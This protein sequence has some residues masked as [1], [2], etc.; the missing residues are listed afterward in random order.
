MECEFSDFKAALDSSDPLIVHRFR[1]VALQLQSLCKMKTEKSVLDELSHLPKQLGDIYS[2]LFEQM[3][4]DTFSFQIAMKALK[5]LACSQRPLPTSDFLI[6]TSQPNLISSSE[7]LD[8]CC[9]LIIEDKNLGIFRFAHLTVREF[10]ES[11]DGFRQVDL[12]ILAAEICLQRVAKMRPIRRQSNDQQPQNDLL[13]YSILFWPVH[14]QLS[15]ELRAQ[16]PLAPLLSTLLVQRRASN[17][18]SKWME[19]ART[20]VEELNEESEIREKLRYSFCSPAHPFFL[21]CVFGFTEVVEKSDIPVAQKCELGLTGLHLASKYGNSEVV[22]IL[23]ARGASNRFRDTYGRTSLFH[24][25]QKGHLKVV[26][27]FMVHEKDIE[28]SNEILKQAMILSQNETHITEMVKLLTSRNSDLLTNRYVLQAA[29]MAPTRDLADYIRNEVGYFESSQTLLEIAACANNTELLEFLLEGEDGDKLI[30]DVDV[31]DC[32]FS[33]YQP[34]KKAFEPLF[35]AVEMSAIPNNELLRLFSR[36]GL[37]P[38]KFLLDSGRITT[39]SQDAFKSAAKHPWDGLEML[40]LLRSH[41]PDLNVDTNIVITAADNRDSVQALAIMEYLLYLN[42][43]VSV[44]QIVVERA[45][46]HG[47]QALTQYLLENFDYLQITDEL[48]EKATTSHRGTTMLKFLLETR[49]N[50]KINQSLLHNAA[51]FADQKVLES[52]LAR[53]PDV[54]VDEQVFLSAVTTNK[55]SAVRFLL[56]HASGLRIS[57]DIIK[58]AINHSDFY[59]STDYDIN[60]ELD[61]PKHPLRFDES[62]NATDI[63]HLILTRVAE[64]R[65]TESISLVAA[66]S[67]NARACLGYLIARYG[68]V[69]VT[70][71]VWIA[72]ASNGYNGGVEV[73]LGQELRPTDMEAILLQVAGMGPSETLD[74]LLQDAGDRVDHKKWNGIASLTKAALSD[75]AGKVRDL[76]ASGIPPIAEFTLPGFRSRSNYLHLASERSEETLKAILETGALDID[77]RDSWGY[78]ALMRAARSGNEATVRLLLQ[79][80][81]DLESQL[82]NGKTALSLVEDA[83][84]AVV[85]LLRNWKLKNEISGTKGVLVSH[86]TMTVKEV[87]SS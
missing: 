83:N 30:I 55:P 67:D 32:L 45:V 38:L 49:P 46:Y 70:D 20:A 17:S 62:H 5:L 81:A 78:T 68:S 47:H 3:R 22:K 13:N 11:R 25:V 10:L 12:H 82:K 66:A 14:S 29:V 48:I 75:E 58:A 16:A 34:G 1:W 28:I 7:M 21:A 73:L 84:S 76:L 36:G 56:S 33:A 85:D 52:L 26:E 23:L 19:A 24:A 51:N 9:N 50:F 41:E 43:R 18:F 37:E 87:P 60:D 71:D 15:G 54:E 86:T 35:P 61:G 63:L 39:I 53:A 72:A 74:L 31:L 8:Y 59:Y 77:A 64:F 65:P 42:P 79:S 80:G 44:T 57:C 69:P 40:K 27:T 2:K 6:A 4:H